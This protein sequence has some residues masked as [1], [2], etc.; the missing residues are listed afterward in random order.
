[1]KLLIASDIHGSAHYTRILL[2][3]FESEGADRLVLL[4]DIL[5]HGPRNDL[6]KEYAP[7]EVAALLNKYADRIIA[8]RGNCEAEVDS[9]MLDF[10]VTPDYGVIFDGERSL[11]ISHGHREI[12]KMP[13]GSAYITGHTHVPHNYTEN[14]I[15]FLNPGSVSIP[16]NNTP[17]SY[18][19]YDNYDFTWV[20]LL[21]GDNYTI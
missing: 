3:A 15:R 10:S 5:Y 12:P 14:G 4:G 9:L 13:C 16:K 11:Y 2:E 8:I 6:P 19:I 7:K 1:M 20:D 18:L 21:N 17:H